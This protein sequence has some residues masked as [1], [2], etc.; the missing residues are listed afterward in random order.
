MSDSDSDGSIDNEILKRITRKRQANP[1]KKSTKKS[2]TSEPVVNHDPLPVDNPDPLPVDP[3]PT[4]PEPPVPEPEPPVSEPVP[5]P[6][7]ESEPEPPVE[8]E[9]VLEEQE[10]LEKAHSVAKKLKRVQMRGEVKPSSKVQKIIRKRPKKEPE[11]E[12]E[13]NNP[14]MEEISRLRQELEDIKQR[15]FNN[16]NQYAPR[17]YNHPETLSHQ[18][19]NLLMGLLGRRFE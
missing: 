12:P 5:E 18:Q 17:P 13:D 6:P 15:G 19:T 2:N 1:A 16:G 14:L 11:P 4:K 8:P 10:K 7:V 3:L 9:H